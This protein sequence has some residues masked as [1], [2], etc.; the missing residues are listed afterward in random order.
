MVLLTPTSTHLAAHQVSGEA[1]AAHC[2]LHMP[3]N[4]NVQLVET[5]TGEQWFILTLRY[6]ISLEGRRASF[7]LACHVRIGDRI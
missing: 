3:A 7:F 5:R 2:N 4:E 6:V 1:E